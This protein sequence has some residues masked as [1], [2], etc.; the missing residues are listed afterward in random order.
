MR[1]QL[2]ARFPQRSPMAILRYGIDST[3]RLE[4]AEGGTM[5]ECGV[6][7]G[8][9]LEDLAAALAEALDDPLQ[10]PP[11]RQCTTPAIRWC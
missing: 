5:V 6:P 11:F 9:P 3:V 7:R 2:T 4:P 8:R 1:F 10:Y